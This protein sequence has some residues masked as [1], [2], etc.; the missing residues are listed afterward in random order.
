MK[1]FQNDA[2]LYAIVIPENAKNSELRFAKA[3]ASIL[4]LPMDVIKTDAEKAGELEIR[5]GKTN[6]T[7]TA[8]ERFEF[9]LAADGK[10]LEFVAGCCFAYEHAYDYFSVNLAALLE[11]E[12]N[13]E[14][15]REDTTAKI[16]AAK[17]T[18]LL[19]KA[20]EIRLIYHNVWGWANAP[21]SIGWQPGNNAE[22]EQRSAIMAESYLE[23]E[24]D[25]IC[26][27][28]YTNFM[29]RACG[30]SGAINILEKNGYAEV[31]LPP[32]D[33]IE[34]AT[35]IVYRTSTL[36]LVD[37]GVHRFT[38]GGGMDKFLTWAVFE[39]LRNGKK[40]AVISAHLAYQGGEDGQS[41]RMAQVPL[42]MYHAELIKKTHKCNVYFGGDMNC[43]GFTDPYKLFLRMGAVDT[44]NLADVTEDRGTCNPY[45]SYDVNTGLVFR[46]RTTNKGTYMTASIDHI[47]H[48]A[49][50]RHYFRKFDILDDTYLGSASDH[51]P[52][53]LD[54]DF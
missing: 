8:V 18:A 25:V 39:T 14:L 17:D 40:F 41:F 1:I 16:K 2:S 52:V 3:V 43:S 35:P 33:K 50:E 22:V 15:Y 51:S 34:T 13:G 29:F 28:E 44:W 20:G 12:K 4:E 27:Q 19:G 32:V 53:L 6:R 45:P 26:M 38:Y 47:F 54:F 42:M 11:E 10:N 7:K 36:N 31:K 49:R 21:A 37:S 9:A 24:P 5:V 30:E 46:P 48:I 23:L